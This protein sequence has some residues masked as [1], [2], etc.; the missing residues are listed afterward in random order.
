MGDA[1]IVNVNYDTYSR[2]VI[3][4]EALTCHVAI[5]DIR[6]MTEAVTSFFFR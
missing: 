3:V 6:C 1:N 5:Y 2:F 4:I